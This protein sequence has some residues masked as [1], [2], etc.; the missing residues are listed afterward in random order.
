MSA[1]QTARKVGIAAA[2]W[3]AAILASRV[4]GLVREAVLGRT[5]GGGQ[6][7]DIY[8]SAFILP[9]YLNYLLAGGALSLVFIPIFSKYL[10]EDKEN[11]GWIAFSH[12]ANSLLLL[13]AVVTPILWWQAPFLATLVAPGFEPPRL[14]RV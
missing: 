3:S 14:G 11:E 7:A 13:L 2:I 8:F 10:V 6:A 9:D 5:L 4:I 1:S 12:I